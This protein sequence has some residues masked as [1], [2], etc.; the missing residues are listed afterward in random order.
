MMMM[1]MMIRLDEKHPLMC[2]VERVV[3]LMKEK[4]FF[5]PSCNA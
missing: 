3:N 4:R 1:M 5:W 2:L